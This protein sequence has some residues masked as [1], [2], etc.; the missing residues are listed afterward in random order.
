M[1]RITVELSP[2]VISQF[3]FGT[4]WLGQVGSCEVV[5][6]LKYDRQDFA[7]VVRIRMQ[8]PKKSPAYLAGRYG[9][10]VIEVLYEDNGVYTCI[11]KERIPGATPEWFGG[12]EMLIDTP[13]MMS[14]E[15]F[16]LSF[17]VKE[18]DFKKV[19]SSI[20]GMVLKVTRQEHVGRGF[21]NPVPALTERQRQIVKL[22]KELGYFEIPRKTSSERIAQILG[23]SK[24]AFLEHLRKVERMVFDEL[25]EVGGPKHDAGGTKPD[26]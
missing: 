8:D 7:G 1:R 12:F 17:L 18:E 22:A 15:K 16:V 3:G 10:D 6:I 5:Y 23:I 21:L 14:K 11:L 4:E 19:M 24:A 9:L 25:A 2:E 20:S 13:I 26:S